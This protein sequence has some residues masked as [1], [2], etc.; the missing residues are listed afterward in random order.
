MKKP[1]RIIK[2]FESHTLEFLQKEIEDV[3]W[4]RE[5]STSAMNLN[6][7]AI[8]KLEKEGLIETP[9]DG[10]RNDYQI[11]DNVLNQLKGKEKEALNILPFKSPYGNYK[12]SKKRSD[13]EKEIGFDKKRGVLENNEEDI[14]VYQLSKFK[15]SPKLVWTGTSKMSK[16]EWSEHPKE[17]DNYVFTTDKSRIPNLPKGDSAHQ[18]AKR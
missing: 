5:T 16:E 13:F 4:K 14:E 8:E 9:Y 1:N 18:G 7:Q 2:T 12:D 15:N 10:K 3:L 17:T 11:V 6:G